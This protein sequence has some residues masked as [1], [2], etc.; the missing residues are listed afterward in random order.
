MLCVY[1]FAESTIDGS[2][3]LEVQMLTW[4]EFAHRCPEISSTGARLL[5]LNEVAFLATV[6]ATERPR[7]HPFVPRIVEHRLVAFI[8][9]SSPK[10]QDLRV[11]EQYA[12]H[13]LP[14]PEDEEFFISG[15]ATSCN[16]D[17]SYRNTVAEAMGFATGVDKHHILYEFNIDRALW[18]RWLDFGTPDHRP[19]RQLW[20][21]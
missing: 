3:E 14:G 6:S 5:E 1:H 13:T 7:I 15:I 4:N 19:D 16:E 18:T 20:R 2:D 11:T 9:D 12:I 17:A 8:M 10:I 21:A